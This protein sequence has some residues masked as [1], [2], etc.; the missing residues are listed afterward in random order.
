M[1]AWPTPRLSRERRQH[2]STQ[3]QKTRH[4]TRARLSDLLFMPSGLQ[5]HENNHI[6]GHVWKIAKILFDGEHA[7]TRMNTTISLPRSSE[8]VISITIF[9]RSRPTTHCTAHDTRH[10]TADDDTAR[11]STTRN[12]H[13]HTQRQPRTSNNPVA[14]WIPKVQLNRPLRP[15]SEMSHPAVHTYQEGPSDKPNKDSGSQNK[16]KP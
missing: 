16:K 4:T 11:Q 7:E 5:T 13:R 3:G 6:H 9:S 8:T 15:S 1:S 12:G 10:G 14:T 2:K